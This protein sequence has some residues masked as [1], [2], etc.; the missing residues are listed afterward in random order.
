MVYKILKEESRRY[1]A[2]KVLMCIFVLLIHA[3]SD[4]HMGIGWGGVGALYQLTFVVSRVICD[5]AVPVFILISSVLLYAK[6]F[7]WWANLKKKSRSLLVPCLIFNS[8]WVVL[9]FVKHVLGQK[10]GVVAGD[11]I[12][13][14]T[15]G[16]FDWLDAYL[17]S[18]G[19]Y[20]PLLTTL[21]YVRDLFLLNLLA[22]PIKK[23]VDWLPI[24]A[25]VATLAVWVLDIQIPGIQDYSLPF[26]VLGLYLVKY[27]IHLADIDR[28]VPKYGILAVY[29]ALTIAVV[30]LERQVEAV[31][32]LYLLSAVLFWLRWSPCLTRFG[33]TIDLIL[34]ATFFL[35]LGHRFVYAIL[36]V[37]VD[38]SLTVYLTTYA[39]KPVV[40]MAVLLAVFYFLRRF[41]PGLLALLVGG[42]VGRRSE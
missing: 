16:I 29:L 9:M 13:F 21:W 33:K 23:V 1:D 3:F 39:L 14:A 40:A 35:Y 7:T 12:D 25:L 11:D 19:D 4:D 5:C 15:Y 20:K 34:P 22:I 27:D 41:L 6:P 28:K 2:L 10:L 31:N 32:R 24:P 42:R 36:Q 17:G 8:L 18:T 30:A 26:F 38:G 37:L